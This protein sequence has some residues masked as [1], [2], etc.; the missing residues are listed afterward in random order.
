MP[1]F[2]ID[3]NPSDFKSLKFDKD[4]KRAHRW[5]ILKF[6]SIRGEPILTADNLLF[7][8][9][10][11]MPT[12]SFEEKEVLGGSISYKFATKPQFSD[13]EISFYDLEGL[14]PKIRKW[15]SLVWTKEKGIG[16]PNDYKDEVIIYLTDGKGNVVD[17]PWVFKNAWPKT[18]NHGALTYDSSDFKLIT[19]TVSYDWIEYSSGVAGAIGASEAATQ[20]VSALNGQLGQIGRFLT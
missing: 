3:T 2:R 10:V 16:M 11:T 13:L 7:A 6:G 8:K 17:D 4:V 5:R 12:F 18:I 1:G 9:S 19:I 15:Y 20:S 14:E